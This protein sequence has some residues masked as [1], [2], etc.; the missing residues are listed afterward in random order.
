MPSDKAF[1]TKCVHSG[2]M[3]DPH[4]RGSI[5]PIYPSTSFAY[6]EMDKKQYPRYF[7][8][9]NQDVLAK[10][11]AE[12]EN[13]ESA[14]VFSS[15]MAAIS[16]AIFSIVK[17]GDHVIVQKGLYG[18]TTNF[19]ENSFPDCGISYDVTKGTAREDFESLINNK[20]R[21]IY[22]ETPSNPLLDITDLEMVADVAG[23]KNIITI[24]DNTFASPVNQ[25]P[26]DYGI[27]IVVHSATKYLGG[28]SDISA[29]AVITNNN[30]MPNIIKKARNF[31][32]NLNA[33]TCYLLERSI[34]T[35]ALRVEQQNKNALEIAKH[36][37]GHKKIEKVF[38]PGLE[39]HT[40]HTIAKRQMHGFGGMLS[41]ELNASHDTT[42]FQKNLKMILPSMSLGGVETTICS[43]ALTSHSLLT[44]QQRAVIGISDQL[45]RLSVGIEDAA[46]I[47]EDIE[48]AMA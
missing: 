22:I 3:I 18:G 26:L 1:R 31:G 48:Q 37:L 34:K 24:I 33:Q 13:G 27:D 17:N 2:S 14:L 8:T 20:T 40:G 11:L 42:Q 38:Y 7:N 10:K 12:L 21:M 5:T 4:T 44:S 43:P 9:P 41:F 46:D 47:I 45:L 35:L 29:G 19:I 6:L 16:T 23:K 15:G 30:L 39:S 25:V 36:L 32:G 28:H